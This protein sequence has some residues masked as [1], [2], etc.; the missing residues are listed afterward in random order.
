MMDPAGWP[1]RAAKADVVLLDIGLPG[2]SGYEVA[3]RLLRDPDFT[4][5][6]VAVSGYG[7]EEDRHQSKEAGIEHHFVKPLDFRQ[8]QQLLDHVWRFPNPAAIGCLLGYS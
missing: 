1:A 8:L 6:L 3:R 4:A 2:M 7:R 5:L